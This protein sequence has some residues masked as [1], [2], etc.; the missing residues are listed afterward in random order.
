MST[1]YALS[2]PEGRSA[3]A[4]FRLSGPDSYSILTKLVGQ[5]DFK[6][7]QL[8]LRKIYDKN[9]L[10]DKALISYFKAPHSFTGEDAAEFHLHGSPALLKLFPKILRK[11]GARLA[12]PGE[13]TKRAFYNDALDLTEIEG[14]SHLI[15]A[16]TEAQHRIA[17]R[18]ADGSARQKF[19]SWREILLTQ[20]ALIEADIDFVEGELPHSFLDDV[21]A[22]VNALLVEI[23]EFI[24]HHQNI[25]SLSEGLRIALVGAPNVGKS[26]L[27]N[28]ILGRDAALVS[29]E[30]G[31]TR[32]ILETKIDFE[33]YP[34]ILAD[35]AGLRAAEG[36]LESLGIEKAKKWQEGADI[37]IHIYAHDQGLPEKYDEGAD[38]VIINKVDLARFPIDNQL[39]VS[40]K[41]EKDFVPIKNA[42]KEIILRKQPDSNAIFY[43]QSQHESILKDL[44]SDLKTLLQQT[45]I[46]LLAADLRSA[47]HNIAKITG[48]VDV[49]D[50]LGKIFSNFCIGK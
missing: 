8:Y 27:Y 19:N 29:D 50:V 25:N 4:V 3:I 5:G 2:T 22:G 35:M 20:L 38:L 11:Y 40:F 47:L 9:N 23:E 41:N 10:I 34:I 31:T 15:Q 18:Q 28:L 45:E 6:P 36:K 17:V 13:F 39:H 26:T 37:K 43:L 14:L 21:K 33:G 16:E 49:E 46:E 12:K 42:L 44:L 48:H 32:D 30:A 24:Q 1:I 7:R